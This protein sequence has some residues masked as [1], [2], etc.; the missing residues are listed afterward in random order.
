MSGE[1]WEYLRLVVRSEGDG[2]WVH[3]GHERYPEEDLD[4]VLTAL[5][6]DRWELAGTVERAE[7]H[8]SDIALHGI[9]V[10]YIRAYQ[11]IFKRPKDDP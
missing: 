10:V 5:G 6:G 9:P 3:H 11:L 2:W 8:P 1:R 7:A 4:R